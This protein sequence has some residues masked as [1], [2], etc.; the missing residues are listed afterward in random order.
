MPA[1]SRKSLYLVAW[2]D[3]AGGTN[4]AAKNQYGRSRASIVV[5]GQDSV[6]RIFILKAWAKRC[7]PDQLVHET[8]ETQRE[9]LPATFGVDASG[10]QLMFA[11]M[12][13]KEAR[14]R[15]IRINL[16][17]T[18]LRMDKTFSIETTLQPVVNQ[19]RLFRPPEPEC[20]YLKGEFNS[21]PGGPY[22]DIMDALACAVR[23]LPAS[24]PEHLRRMGQNQLRDY[25]RRIGMPEDQ[26][27]MKMIQH[28]EALAA[29]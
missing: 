4:L 6:E 28:A 17:P 25:L 21:F 15:G 2:L 13:R 14:E 16:R 3:P 8:F 22:Q 27:Q 7:P 11:Q 9:F 1:V 29:K 24:L 19:G 12:L 20:A 5:I 26:I 23:L 10:P 18:P